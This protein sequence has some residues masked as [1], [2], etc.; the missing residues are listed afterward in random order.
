MIFKMK[1]KSKKNKKKAMVITYYPLQITGLPSLKLALVTDLHDQDPRPLL[2]QLNQEKPDFILLAGDIMERRQEGYDGHTME[3]IDSYQE[4]SF[5]WSHFC[6]F[7]KAFHRLLYKMGLPKKEKRI[8]GRYFLKE[9]SGIA[10]VY[11]SKGNHEWYFL[12]QD[13]KLMRKH[14]ITLLDNCDCQI[15]CKNSAIL[16]IGGLSTMHDLDWLHDY[17]KKDGTKILL[18]HHPEYYSRFIKDSDMKFDLILSGHAHGG[19]WRFLGK[20]ILAPGQGL[21]PKYHHGRY[22]NLIV[23]AGVSNTS[24]LPRL[25]N[26]CEL[27]ILKIN[28]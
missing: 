13:Y 28:S 22:H 23:S 20:G 21:F 14:G 6:N 27:V 10:P 17:A 3:E 19:Q 24:F 4:I 16:R 12:P 5:L 11:M 1:K 9:A 26:P 15:T 8:Y 2:E 18:C 7:L 25:G